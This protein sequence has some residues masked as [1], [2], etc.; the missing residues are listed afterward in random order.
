MIKNPLQLQLQLQL[1]LEILTFDNGF[2]NC[3]LK[4]AYAALLVTLLMSKFQITDK[5]LFKIL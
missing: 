3:G 5:L 4:P 2:I 1:Q